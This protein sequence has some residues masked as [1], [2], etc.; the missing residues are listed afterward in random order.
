M[1]NKYRGLPFWCWNG[2]LDKEELLRQ[3]HIMKDMGFGGFFMH[4]RTGLETE[5]LGEEWLNIVKE[6]ILEAKKIGLTAWLYDE[7]RWPSGTA[8]G[9]VTKILEFQ[10]KFISM[11]DEASV[12]EPGVYI[13]CQLGRFAIKIASDGSM[14]DYYKIGEGEALKDGYVIKKFLVEHM[15]E[16]QFYN[17]YTYLDTMNIN[18]TNAFLQSTHE[19]YKAKCG[20]LFG[21]TLMGVFTDEPYRGSVLN[22]F[23]MDN[24]NRLN[25]IPYTYQ[26]YSKYKAI[27]GENLS[28]K[29]PELFYKKV[30]SKIN[31]TMYYYIETIQ[32]LFLENFAKPY[33]DWCQKNKLIFTG[34]VLHEDSLAIQTLFQG[35]VQRFYEYMDYPGI[36]V[37][38]EYNNAYWIAK[39]VQS[40]A[41]Q[42][43]KE[44][45]LSEM[46]GGTGWQLNFQSHRD[47]GVWQALLG[48][49]LRCHHLS[50][51]TMAGEAK[52]DYPASIFFQSCW[53]KDY[54]FIEDYFARLGNLI[55]KGK[56]LCDVLVINPVESAWLYP[57]V[58]WEKNY[59]DPQ[60]KE[61][62]DLEEK[63]LK[64][65]NIL[66]TAQI[67]FDYG[68]EDLL[69]RYAKV[70]SKNDSTI[71]KFGKS[72][73]KCIVICGMDTIRSSTLKI[74]KNFKAKGGKV[75]VVGDE[76]LYVNAALS[77]E[78]SVLSIFDHI[79]FQYNQI[80][81]YLKNYRKFYVDSQDVISMIRKMKDGY[82][83]I[84]LNRDREKDK[85]NLTLFF[86]QRY[87]VNEI[88]LETGKKH[89]LAE[90]AERLALNFEAGQCRVF[91]VKNQGQCEKFN[92]QDK[93]KTKIVIQNAMSYRLSENN[94][95]P[96]D[97]AVYTLD[98]KICEEKKEILQI[99]R[100]VRK[101]LGISL[102]GGEMIQPWYRKKY[103]VSTQNTEQHTI[104][105]K[106]EFFV[107]SLP[108]TD[109]KLILEQSERWNININN[110]ALDK[111]VV[112]HWID[113]C[114]D[115]IKLPYKNLKI[116]RNVLEIS[117]E[118]DDSLNLEC[119]YIEGMFGV[120]LEGNKTI[121]K[122]L[123]EKLNI[124]DI[125]LQGLPF[126]SGKIIYRTGI[127]DKRLR[128]K[129]QGCYG[130]VSKVVSDRHYE[131]IA[132]PPYESD[133]FDCKGELKIEIS[134]TRRNT[135][136][137]L[138][139][140]PVFSNAYGPDIFIQEGENYTNNYCLIK[141]GLLDNVVIK[142]YDSI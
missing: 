80:V 132:F 74:L 33:H 62:K 141:Q 119:I 24:K 63:Y 90:N 26:L 61:I 92:I 15:K 5:Y 68:D 40:I 76:P 122:N 120:G 140:A 134:L 36:D 3:V 31:R 137:P 58:G 128:V 88:F 27:T 60:V 37:L 18:A 124:G 101:T 89:G 138:H 99:D 48:I 52:R 75:V 104:K 19:K 81:N 102:R 54:K 94:I 79:S 93:E 22:G 56:P 35:S 105:L 87:N 2:K 98:D 77:N 78:T 57:C 86:D 73:Y 65:F 96:L 1:L 28:D 13:A 70:L 49:S 113:Q 10:M 14:L 127:Y 114:F 118:F 135:F 29:L 42:L 116:G 39:Q 66:T 108:K 67:D 136:G 11:Y 110:K 111:I 4:S 131:Y 129:L 50:W 7:D 97:L 32:Q 115:E 8:G 91:E 123:P 72:E 126:Y 21:K 95:L 71:L 41:R 106:Y 103:G 130:A 100:E 109:Y 69:A 45:T 12:P 85:K 59:F 9:E 16:N 43:G 25:M 117:A 47:I 23:G 55:N 139:Y 44:N 84:C 83:I 64:L 112:G 107:E 125:A 38:T 133:I 17:G 53:Y 121:I 142:I 30:N 34:H 20:E 46:Y 6:V 82:Y 51:Y